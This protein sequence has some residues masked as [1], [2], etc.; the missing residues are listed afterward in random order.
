[1]PFVSANYKNHPDA[2]EGKWV[3]ARTSNLGPYAAHPEPHTRSNPNYCGQCV[4]FVTTVCPTIPVTTTQWVKGVPVKGNTTIVEGTAI[5]TFDAQGNYRGHAAI[6]VGQN[7]EGI[8]VYDQWITGAGKAIGSRLIK[9]NGVGV[10]NNG[11]GF[12]VVEA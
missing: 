3:C 12:Y 8:E 1:M 2:P 5:A 11:D 6:Y 9:W 10:S 4:S 7:A